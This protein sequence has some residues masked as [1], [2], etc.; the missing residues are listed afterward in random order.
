MKRVVAALLALL[1]L[2]GLIVIGSSSPASAGEC[3]AE[4]SPTSTTQITATWN[5]SGCS[6]I[7]AGNDGKQFEICWSIG[8]AALPITACTQHKL[9]YANQ[10]GSDT[11]TAE[12]GQNFAFKASYRKKGGLSWP[13]VNRVSVRTPSAVANSGSQS[14]Q[15][16]NK[17]ESIFEVKSAEKISLTWDVSGCDRIKSGTSFEVCWSVGPAALPAG[18]CFQHRQQFVERTGTT[19]FVTTPSTRYAFKTSYK[20]SSNQWNK[21]ATQQIDTPSASAP[22]GS[23]P[24]SQDVSAGPKV[25]TIGDSYASGT[26]YYTDGN[27]YCEPV[28]S[29]LQFGP[30]T[31]RGDGECWRAFKNNETPGPHVA[32]DLG[33]GSLFLACKGAKLDNAVNQF[34][35]AKSL[36]PSQA[37]KGFRGSAFVVNISGND[38]TTPDHE[39]WTD[40]MAECVMNNALWGNCARPGNEFNNLPQVGAKLLNFYTMLA[41]EAPN[42]KIRQFLYPTPMKVG[43]NL[44]IKVICGGMPTVLPGEADFGDAQMA[45]LNATIVS[46]VASVTATYPNLDLKLVDANTTFTSG[47]C[48]PFPKNLIHGVVAIVQGPNGR[49]VN[50]G[51]PKAG[52][53]KDGAPP[54]PPPTYTAAELSEPGFTVIRPDQWCA[55]T[56]SACSPRVP[57]TERTMINF[58]LPVVPADPSA[59][60]FKYR[61][62]STAS[63]HPTV[64]G[65]DAYYTALKAGW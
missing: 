8:N 15:P 31:N 16:A 49:L 22:S 14:P 7:N 46:T 35:L 42:A 30:L 63:F 26:G 56:K 20:N 32:S 53:G 37:A 6:K 3:Y 59:R 23:G 12:P 54:L 34:K 10:S 38:V 44:G 39:D 65:W 50:P 4:F 62:I 11:F 36:L 21:V 51:V 5:V 13:E 41:T 27:R 24:C 43:A 61:L 47:V 45:R 25:I 1:S 28:S 18:A 33:M 64:R 2:S 60:G 17:C 58:G 48:T 9:Q 55:A 57:V 52:E 19:D 40:V 29:E